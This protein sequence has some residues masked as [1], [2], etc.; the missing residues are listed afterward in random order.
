MSEQTNV[1]PCE[2]L[3]EVYVRSL[4]KSKLLDA[5]LSAYEVSINVDITNTK[6]EAVAETNLAMVREELLRR[7][8]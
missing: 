6:F 8:F 4:G 5:Y 1:P 3:E 2:P 7:M